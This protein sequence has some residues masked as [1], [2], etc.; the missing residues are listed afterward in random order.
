M[1]AWKTNI[2]IKNKLCTTLA[3]YLMILRSVG[4]FA[5]G[6]WTSCKEEGPSEK[7]L[8]FSHGLE[9]TESAKALS[10][11]YFGLLAI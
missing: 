2:G 7:L 8:L 9:R 11:K 3:Q 1:R 5:N 6:S 10:E 4:Q